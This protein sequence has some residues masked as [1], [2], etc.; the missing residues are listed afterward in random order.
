MEEKTLRHLITTAMHIVTR[1]T[2]D[3]NDVEDESKVMKAASAFLVKQF[4]ETIKPKIVMSSDA[5]QADLKGAYLAICEPIKVSA[6]EMCA[7]EEEYE[8][9][10]GM[11]VKNVVHGDNVVLTP[12]TDLTTV[13]HIISPPPNTKTIRDTKFDAIKEKLDAKRKSSVGEHA[14]ESKALRIDIRENGYE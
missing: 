3:H 2:M 7:M 14:G 8:R 9:L 1:G 5:L 12:T 10:T 4:E 13:N 11:K 6:E